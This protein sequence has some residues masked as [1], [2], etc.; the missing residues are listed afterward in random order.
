M[1]Q[2]EM[3][4]AMLQHP[5]HMCRGSRT[6]AMLKHSIPH[7]IKFIFL[8]ILGEV[9]VMCSAVACLSDILKRYNYSFLLFSMKE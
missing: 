2:G 6:V 9:V 8:T 5:M 1:M 7:P 3:L 4:D